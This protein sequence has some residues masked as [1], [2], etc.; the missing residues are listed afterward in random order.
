MIMML[1]DSKFSHSV[2]LNQNPS[3]V[4]KRIS[5]G[6]ENNLIIRFWRKTK[7]SFISYVFTFSYCLEQSLY[8]LLPLFWI[9]HL[10]FYCRDLK[11]V[12]L[13]DARK[14]DQ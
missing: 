6:K 4:L 9:D 2:C 14:F 1:T 12:F 7:L 13:V 8:I 11:T 5:E 3:T 10:G